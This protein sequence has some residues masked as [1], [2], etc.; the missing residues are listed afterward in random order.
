[1]KPLIL[2]VMALLIPSG[3]RAAVEAVS[4]DSGWLL[5]ERQGTR[6]AWGIIF[7][8]DE[9]TSLRTE[10]STTTVEF[11]SGKALEI[12]PGAARL[13]MPSRTL[14]LALRRGSL[15]RIDRLGD[16]R[17]TRDM[18]GIVFELRE[19]EED[20]DVESFDLTLPDDLLSRFS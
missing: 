15:Y 19:D 18:S 12:N 5:Y 2:L 11:A 7:G 10:G 14:L 6:M 16:V 9:L 17:E 8:G 13:E 1:M 4:I 20:G 3:V